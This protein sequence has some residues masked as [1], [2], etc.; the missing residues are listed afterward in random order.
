MAPRNKI[1]VLQ[2]RRK[3][4]RYWGASND[5]CATGRELKQVPSETPHLTGGEGGKMNIH[6]KV[7]GGDG[8]P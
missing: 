3:G 4:D 7:R 1:R 5:I 6:R 8:R 2:A